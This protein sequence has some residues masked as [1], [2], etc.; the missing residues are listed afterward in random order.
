MAWG[1]AASLGEGVATSIDA[2]DEAGGESVVTLLLLLLADAVTAFELDAWRED[3]GSFAGLLVFSVV[4]VR[5]STGAA[6][7]GVS[8]VVVTPGAVSVVASL[9]VVVE[10]EATAVSARFVCGLAMLAVRA[11]LATG[12]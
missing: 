9:I 3:F 12:S 6:G 2:L 4:T 8:A 10:F 1:V 7:F 5:D 11:G